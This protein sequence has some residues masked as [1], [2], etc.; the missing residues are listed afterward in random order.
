M[1]LCFN[2]QHHALYPTVLISGFI[3]E[4]ASLKLAQPDRGIFICHSRKNAVSVASAFKAVG[5]YLIG[6]LSYSSLTSLICGSA[7]PFLMYASKIA[8]VSSGTLRVA[9]FVGVMLWRMLTDSGPLCQATYCVAR[10]VSC[11]C[12]V[13]S[14]MSMLSAVK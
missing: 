8:F 10:N 2:C 4:C 9:I 5:Q 3:S 6:W 1:R 7:V 14:L 12:S 11:P 13:P